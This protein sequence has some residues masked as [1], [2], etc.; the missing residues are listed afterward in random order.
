MRTLGSK[1]QLEQPK[2]EPFAEN[3][4]W[5]DRGPNPLLKMEAEA[6]KIRT[7]GSK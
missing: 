2:S 3:D 1:F 5:S 4:C 7:L 6:A